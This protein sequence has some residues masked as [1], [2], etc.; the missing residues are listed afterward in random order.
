MSRVQ[1]NLSPAMHRALREVAKQEGVAPAQL[2]ASAVAEKVAALRTAELLRKKPTTA[3]RG[4]FLAFLAKVPARKPVK[5]DEMPKA[6][7]QKLRRKF[8]L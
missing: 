6:L 7:Q 1:V 8:G 4:K 2:I 5:G 3:S